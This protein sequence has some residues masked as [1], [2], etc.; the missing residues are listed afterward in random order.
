MSSEDPR[1]TA[2]PERPP[3]SQVPVFNAPLVVIALCALI[4]LA[5]LARLG[6]FGFQDIA[7]NFAI[8]I[9]VIRTGPVAAEIP[10]APVFGLSPYVMHVFVHF[11]WLHL[12]M[13][14]GILLAVGSVTARAFG[15]GLSGALGFLA[16]FFACAIGGGVMATV[17]SLNDSSLVAGASSAISGLIASAGWLRG[18]R[19]GMLR[20]ALPWLGL[21]IVLALANAVVAIPISWAGHVGGLVVGMLAFPLFLALF[22]NRLAGPRQHRPF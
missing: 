19:A 16:F 1:S 13:N 2:S 17:T 12:M 5:H 14:V 6:T 11:G 9:G 22:G 3:A 4:V 10:Q 18:G 20:L 7:E 21:N 15:T 8:W